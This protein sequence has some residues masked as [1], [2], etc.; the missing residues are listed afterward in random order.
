M[1]YQVVSM[2]ISSIQI[3]NYK[4]HSYTFIPKCSQFHIF[5]GRNSS[6]KSSILESLEMIKN[7]DADSKVMD[8]KEKVFQ[9]LKAHETKDIVLR[10]QI[11]LLDKEMGKYIYEYFRIQPSFI[12]SSAVL[13][14]IILSFSIKINGEKVPQKKFHNRIVLRRMEISDTN[15]N[16]VTI[17]KDH[18]SDN[19]KI[20]LATFQEGHGPGGQ[21]PP[22]SDF[23]SVNLYLKNIMEANKTSVEVTA[24]KTVTRL[25]QYDF[26]REFIGPFTF[27][28]PIRQSDKRV[29]TKF[30]DPSE[31]DRYG[32]NLV[33]SM[34]VMYSNDRER[35]SAVLDVCKK[36][37]P[38]IVDIRPERLRDDKV[39][40]VVKKY[41]I[42]ERIEISHEASG[43]DQ[44]L[45]IIWKI[46]TSEF[47]TIW[48]LDE[49][50]LH[51]H[52]GAQ[53]ILYEFLREESDK[54]K[55]ILVATHSMVFMHN[56]N[57][58]EV[59]LVL[60]DKGATNVK[61]LIDIIPA[62]HGSDRA[63]IGN[64]ICR[65][66]YDALGYDP[67]FA[68]EPRT[69][70]FVEGKADEAILTSISKTLEME[71]NSRAVR[72]IPIGDKIKAEN[73]IPILAFTVVGKKCLIVL[74]NDNNLLK[75]LKKI[76]SKQIDYKNTTG[77]IPTLT[78]NNFHLYPE[79]VYSI[80][81]Y[82]LEP[83]AIFEAANII[84][85]LIRQKI[86]DRLD[87]EMDAI[88]TKKLKPKDVLKSIW[89]DNALLGPYKEVDTAVEISKCISKDYLQQ[90]EEI[91][92]LIIAMKN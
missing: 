86:T 43:L 1:D 25:F 39:T 57:H 38:D 42:P 54:G 66:L 78:D 61:Q 20:N 84:D 70:V 30:L 18:E 29:T 8:I 89:E 28:D 3:E 26:L 49:P 47:G 65:Q 52:P 17:L 14:R 82:L 46:A 53:Q 36:V 9:G 35:F 15:D 77:V 71:I 37:F 69:L 56:S 50:E 10:I 33:N 90:H 62:D 83:E 59:S 45:I 67:T 2:K 11:E 6:G 12:E 85:P 68:F 27:I 63:V 91:K 58:D 72:F 88:K 51:L 21:V 81:Y 44:L 79:N 64:I 76:L 73:H 24:L 87:K 23:E 19:N 7:F 4:S 74:D 32:S 22:F 13:K 5:I 75:R 40:I 34:D 48:L 80:E 16:L 55:Q 41:D 92:N 31:V 60:Y